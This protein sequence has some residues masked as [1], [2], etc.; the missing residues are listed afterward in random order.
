MGRLIGKQGRYV[1]YLKQNSGAKIYISTLPYTQD[2]Q[3]CHIE[4]ESDV[5][6][7]LNAS[8]PVTTL[9]FWRLGRYAAAGGQSPVP[10]REEVQGPG[11]DQPVRPPSSPAGAPLA[12]HDLL[13][14]AGLTVRLGRV[15]GGPPP[16]CC[17]SSPVPPLRSC[18]S[19]A[20]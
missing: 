19:P 4:G 10:D 9:T 7:S 12:T 18:S 5:P 13:G 15:R 20:A 14:K 16:C 11:P 17:A 1:S 6:R 2:F 8:C 3:I